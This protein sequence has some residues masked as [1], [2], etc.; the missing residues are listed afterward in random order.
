MRT[1]SLKVEASLYPGSTIGTESIVEQAKKL[2]SLGFDRAFT[3][4][5]SRDPFNPLVLASHATT[6][7]ELGTGIAVA[8]ARN[9]MN[10][11]V[12]A[13]DLNVYSNGRFRL[14]LGSQIKPHITRRF[15]MPW[16][17]AA[18]Q[19]REFVQAV[20][21]IWDSWF[22][23]VPLDYQ[24]EFYQYSLMTPEFS[25]TTEGLKRPP[26]LLAAVGPLMLK[27]AA[28]VAD[29]LIVHPFCTEQ[30]LKEVIVPRIEPE[31]E[32]RGRSLEDFEIQYPI[33]IASGDT[34]EQIDKAKAAVRQRIG[35]YG[36]TPAYKAV[37]D[38]HGWGDLQPKL[39]TMTKENKWGQ[40]GDQ[41]TDEVL[42]TFAAVGTPAE[43]ANIVRDRVGGVADSVVLDPSQPAEVLDVQMQILR[44]D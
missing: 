43:A 4:E 33:F 26:I 25:P 14:G 2:E 3:A 19:M 40:L 24:G 15:S 35:F 20:H 23:G 12:A 10:V 6:N 21:A 31:L 8:F 36:S 9:P 29:G 7:L 11:A 17:G 34:D 22:D 28:Q 41:I 1:K 30:Y 39:R 32:A 16:H 42:E 37:L 18:K 44:A 38:L 27:T 5:T 13:Q